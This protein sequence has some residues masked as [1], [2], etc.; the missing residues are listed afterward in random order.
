ML[1]C[2][3]QQFASQYN[4]QPVKCTPEEGP[5]SEELKK[6]IAPLSSEEKN[7]LSEFFDFS[8]YAEQ[9]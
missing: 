6:M 3:N 2:A 5:A 9:I 4:M 8:F 7:V 1:E